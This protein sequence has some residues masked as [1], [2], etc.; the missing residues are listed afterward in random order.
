M[1]KPQL[2]Y[3]KLAS[4][5]QNLANIE[6]IHIDDSVLN[7]L[8][9]LGALLVALKDCAS[10]PQ[11]LSILFLYF[12][13]HYSISV[14]NTAA[15]YVSEI[16]ETTFDP[17]IGEFGMTEDQK[18]KWLKCLKECQ[19]NWTLVIRND[20]F[21]K[22]SHVIS[23]CI[24]LGLC[25][26]SS[27]DFKVGGM[28]L[29]SLGAYTKQASAI[30]L[31]DAAF[32]TIVYFAE[33][34][35][36]CFVRGS[37]KPLLYGNMDNE[38]FEETF[39]ACSRCHEYAK[40]GNL[41]KLENMSENDYEALLEKCQE[42]CKYL[43]RT[44]RGIVEKNLLQKKLDIV[45]GFQAT[46]RQTRVQGGL[47]E[48]PY[49]IGVFGG[50]SV[51]KSTV[52]NVLMV[53]SLLTNGYSATDD[54]IMT[55]DDGDKFMSNYR[56]YV[57]GIL[58]DDIGNTKSDF[59]EKAPTAMKLKI[60]N[61]VRMYAHMAEAE[62]KGKVSV[63]PKVYIETKNVKDACAHVYSN[64]PASIARRDRITLT[65][66]VKPQYA[67]YSMLDDDKVREHCPH[68][69]VEGGM[70]RCPDLW[71]ITVE[72]AFPVTP[73]TKN[74]VAGIGWETISYNGKPLINIGLPELIRFVKHDSEK[75]FKAQA[76]I[77]ARSNNI[78]EQ[79]T[80]CKTCRLPTPDVC[81]CERSEQD[82]IPEPGDVLNPDILEDSTAE[83]EIQFP[84]FSAQKQNAKLLPRASERCPAGIK[85]S[86]YCGNCDALHN[87]VLR[88]SLK[89]PKRGFCTTCNTTHFT[90]CVQEPLLCTDC[91]VYHPQLGEVMASA[92]IRYG[93]VLSYKYMPKFTYWTNE[94][95]ERTTEFLIA[96]LEWLETSRWTR[97]TNW[98]PADW[99]K[100]TWCENVILW[101]RQQELTERIRRTY[102]NHIIIM[103]LIVLAGRVF[104]LFFILIVPNCIA[105]ANVVKFEKKKLYNEAAAEND[106]MPA[107]FKLYRDRHVK[108][109]TGACLV[110]GALYG[111]AMVWRTMKVT[112]SAQGNIAP[113]GD[114]E[115]KERDSEVNPWAGVVV[116]E[117]P[118]T[119]K[120]KTTTPDTLEKLVSANLCHMR[121]EVDDN[122]NTRTFECDAFFPK[123]NVAL[124]PQHMWLADDIRAKF[125]R[126]DPTKIGGNFE[127]YLHRGHS[128]DIPNTDFSLVWVPN[129]GDW[130]DLTPYLPTQ[131]F[132]NNVPARL[133]FKK[134]DGDIVKSKTLM[135]M[136]EVSTWAADFYGAEYTLTFETFAGL[137]MAPLITE[138]KG[139]LIGGFH[140][141]GLDDDPRGCCGSLT[142]DEINTAFDALRKKKSVVLSKSAGTVP[143]QVYDVQFFENT[144]VHPKSPINFLPHGTNCKYYGQ[145][146][147]RATYHSDVEETV[148][149]KYV[150]DICGVPQQWGGPKFGGKNNWPWQASLQ[151]STKPSIGIEGSLLDRACQDYYDGIVVALTKFP[152]LVKDI[153][154]LNK[155]EV[156]CGRD[157]VRFIDKMPSDTSIG[158]PLSGPKSNYITLLDPKD[159]NGFQCPAELDERFWAHAKQMEEL[160]LAGERAYPI[161]KACLK[162]EPTKLTKDKVRVF[163][164]APC[165]FQLLI[166]KYFLPVAR[167]LSM[168]P[169]SSECAVGIN[170]QG[171]EWDQLAKYV[172]K[173]GAD[174]ILAGDYSKYDLRM[175]AQVM[176]AAFKIMI[177]I[178][179]FSGNYT[180]RDIVI[181]E[182]IATDVCYPLMAYNGDLIQHYGS[183]PSGQNLTVYVNSIVNSLL[184]RCAYFEVTKNRSFVPPFREACSLITYG[185][186]AKS[187]VHEAFPE[188]NHI[189]VA[190]FL[191]K[192]DMKFTMPDKES[193]PT[194]YMKDE[195]ADL[196]KRKNIYSEDTGKIMGALDEDSIFKSLHATLKSKALTREQQSMQ[197]IDG[198][199]REWFAHGRDKYEQRRSE[200][201]QVAKAADIAHG[202]PGLHLT[203][204]D[205]LAAWKEKYD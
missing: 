1:F 141:G 150:E 177:D 19:E 152:E 31:V 64:E 71:D 48:A 47:R 39:A 108:W 119:T 203:Y 66:K 78:A 92:L 155:M 162:D 115:I 24:A 172:K 199:L 126:H 158:Y 80:L 157:G 81:C 22:L 62:L 202:I 125:I 200:M 69:Y 111:V 151:Y 6:G 183:N 147:G 27:L 169:L 99:L 118:C 54:R 128:V 28:K 192:H 143:K 190:D 58:F 175:P 116:S 55:L 96:R 89:C 112:P 5:F 163:Q 133:V 53:T 104:P 15:T 60:C 14:A 136:K 179:R 110:V 167:I 120:S 142:L 102:L 7:K 174:R 160:Y 100:Q 139:P 164:G 187:S 50:T 130:K 188:F 37:I 127:A 132:S 197:N 2:G 156:V 134:P 57:N 36:M 107:I 97:W 52:A 196:L 29:F 13:T 154:P 49:A 149:S 41:E 8:E 94:I 46:F 93:R 166:R 11:F 182:G 165:A 87:R 45:R 146:T 138:T 195:D 79:M 122:G 106:A 18:P 135:E 148:I 12:K 85:T 35:Y 123:S 56:S 30:D 21:K 191:A 9:N 42:K 20:G 194:P 16:F 186:D 168:L 140:L 90:S 23:L 103:I 26:A 40:A 61:N 76:N 121:I 109:I 114:Q 129:G 171:P 153:R 117:M 43:I 33:G 67:T 74:G 170:A 161:Y 73:K 44:S 181:M 25:D 10:T 144:D 3:N 105:I 176:F 70:W 83:Q 201:H 173:F 65:V 68:L 32:E 205:R 180:E 72:R 38:E 88:K 82:S 77:V 98:I 51:G 91:N 184:F 75:F 185:D 86:A 17:Q 95:E 131:H 204:D 4:A 178:A 59:V 113:K 124:V 145:V 34:G 159:H 137:C 198:G 84:I 193:E 189:A 101:S 63:E